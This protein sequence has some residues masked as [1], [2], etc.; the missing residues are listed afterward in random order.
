MY[1]EGTLVAVKPGAFQGTDGKPVKWFTNFIKTEAEG[2]QIEIYELNSQEDLTEAEGKT[3]VFSL[4]LY[5]PKNVFDRDGKLQK[6]LYKISV[7]G[8]RQQEI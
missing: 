2:G 8:F 1:A 6:G 5:S 3:G 7:V 4:R